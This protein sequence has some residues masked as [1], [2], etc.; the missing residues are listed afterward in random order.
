MATL[1]TIEWTGQGSLIPPETRVA[2]WQQADVNESLPDDLI[3]IEGLAAGKM[4]FEGPANDDP[5]NCRLRRWVGPSLSD[6]PPGI[7]ENLPRAEE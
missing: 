1:K 4:E 6:E 3:Q 5:A 7:G 2:V